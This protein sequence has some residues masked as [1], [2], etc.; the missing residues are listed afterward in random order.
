M[1][2]ILEKISD[3]QHIMIV[4]DVESLAGA[5]ALYTHVLRLHKKV[6]LVCEDKNIDNKLSF[7]PWF[8][9][10]RTQKLS[11]ADLHVEFDYGSYEL[12]DY[13]KKNNIKINPKMATALYAGLLQESDGFL[14]S[15]VNGMTFAMAKELVECGAEYKICSSFIMKYTTLASIR[16]KAIM[17]KNMLLVNDAKTALFEIK[18]DDLKSAGASLKD[19][20][21]VLKE[22][23]KLPHTEEVILLHVDK[24]YELLRLK[25]KEI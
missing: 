20:D 7:L 25:Y 10:I 18:N 2:S 5:S 21:E 1:N 6:S 8:D 13:F 16:L 3:A 23:L 24:E 9:K 17:F 12:Y 22:T 19:C 15:S 14:N 11:S 4:A